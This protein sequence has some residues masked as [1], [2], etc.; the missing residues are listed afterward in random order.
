MPQSID[1]SSYEKAPI[2]EESWREAIPPSSSSDEGDDT[3]PMLK[4]K[5]TPWPAKPIRWIRSPWMFLL[6]F[7]MIALVTIF[8][9][10]KPFTT[11]MDFLGDV[12][13]FIPRFSQ[14]ITTF[15]AHPEFV[16]NH[17]SLESL[18]EAR[19]AWME[20]LPRELTNVLLCLI[21]ETYQL[22]RRSRLC[23]Y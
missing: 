7:F 15:R 2:L 17:T 8:Y 21:K 20:F 9:G 18:Q 11:H 22:Y 14:Q 5:A 12:T 3:T 1:L 16:S 4:K 13:G 23:H 6:D 10:Q 19:E